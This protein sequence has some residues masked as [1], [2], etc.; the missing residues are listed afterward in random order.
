MT[1]L[2]PLTNVFILPGLPE[3]AA[4]LGTSLAAAQ[5]A[6]SVGFAGLAVGLLVAGPLSD[7]Y[8]RRVLMTVG[9]LLYVATTLL[10]AFAPDITILIVG[11]F[12]Q[13]ATGGSVWVIARAIVRDVFHARATARAFSQ[14]AMITGVAPVIAPVI[15]GQI[16]L[17]TDWRGLLFT[18]A[19]LGGSVAVLAF[20][21]M[22]ET[23]PP[24]R[25]H[26]AG[27]V[28]RVRMLTGL[29][30]APFFRTFLALGI[31]QSATYFT[32]LI[33]SPFVFYGD[34]GFNAQMFAVLFAGAALSM[35]IGNQLNVLLLRRW[36]PD[37]LLRLLLLMSS[38]GAAAFLGATL[39]A[40]P[41]PVVIGTM[42]L[43]TLTTG[44]SNSNIT[45]LGLAPYGHIAGSAAALL[46][47]CQ[48]TVGA[49]VPP[50]V[51]LIGVGGVTMGITMLISAMVAW[52]IA[53]ATRSRL[54]PVFAEAMAADF[55]TV[56]EDSAEAGV[57]DT[58]QPDNIQLKES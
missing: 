40:A 52:L 14:L 35:V 48:F 41:L 47:A 33:M 10:C 20:A 45:A 44:A 3:I 2:S 6:L 42:L 54:S 55:G 32:F 27:A 15:A 21:F 24:E 18:L 26:R 5:F 9:L 13:G 39:L 11:R 19:V 7:A 36:P 28:G 53:V 51:S 30:S 29:L 8:G 17:F 25:R 34:Y 56:G 58:N 16:L 37:T 31:V 49:L 38:V 12:L 57:L 43:I 50:L 46:G 22:R 23:L 1:A 4:D